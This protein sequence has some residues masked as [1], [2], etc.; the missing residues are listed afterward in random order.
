[1]TAREGFMAHILKRLALA[2][3]AAIALGGAA[4]ACDC[5]GGRPVYSCYGGGYDCH[6]VDGYGRD[7]Y[8]GPRYGGGVYGTYEPNEH[9]IINRDGY[10]GY[11]RDGVRYDRDGYV[12]DEHSHD[13]HDG[14]FD[15]HDGWHDGDGH[16]HGEVQRDGHWYEGDGHDGDW[17]GGVGHDGHDGGWHDGSHDGHDGAWHGGDGH[18]GDGHDGGWHGGRH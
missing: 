15:G 10:D 16:W 13:W 2:G 4:Q 9:Y 14:H 7:H 3:V 11:W 17:H 6:F 18:D 12:R 5:Y 8:Y 1:M